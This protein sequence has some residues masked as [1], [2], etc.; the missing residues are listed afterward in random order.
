[1]ATAVL[2]AGCSQ[3]ADS[4]DPQGQQNPAPQGGTVVPGEN[5]FPSSGENTPPQEEG[6]AEIPEEPVPEPEMPEEPP[7]P[8]PQVHEY[9]I[10]GDDRGFYPGDDIVVNAGDTVRINF[11]VR[12]TNV[13]YAGLLIKSRSGSF[14]TGNLDPGESKT[15]EFT[16]EESDTITSY[17]PSSG[18][19]KA[20]LS[21]IVN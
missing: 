15:I 19:R 17:W 18:V 12:T 6:P 13:Y 14:T 20:D 10:E 9:S 1:M 5:P 4:P 7:A 21:V 2:F 11:T 3:P 16:A 8:Q